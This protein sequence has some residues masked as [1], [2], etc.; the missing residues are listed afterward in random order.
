MSSGTM[1]TSNFQPRR[2][3]FVDTNIQGRL[4]AGLLLLEIIVFAA[5]MGFVYQQLQTA[6]D[7]NLYR[8]HQP[9]AENRA[10]LFNALVR[11]IPWIIGVNI[12]MLIGIDRLWANY[13]T[14]I[15]L[16]L[17]HIIERVA[18][19][20]LHSDSLVSPHHAVL[21]H[22]QLWVEAEQER[23]GNL[24]RLVQSIPDTVEQTDSTELTRLAEILQQIKQRLP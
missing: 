19:F 8:V 11:T 2:K 24:R 4:I 7:I 15:I 23:C 12:L 14:K 16:S 20:D 9:D 5:A 18:Q 1:K 6:I 10:V 22:A 3:K 17:R 13:V 21:H